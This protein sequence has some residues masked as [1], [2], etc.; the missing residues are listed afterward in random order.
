MS[1]S[2][3]IF[4]ELQ[5]M[6]AGEFAHLN[7]S[8]EEHLYGTEALLRSWAASEHVCRAGLF[9]AAYGTAGFANS[10]TPI[11]LR[12]EIRNLIGQQAEH[13][14][15][16]YCACDRKKFY[17]S[18]GSPEQNQLPDRFAGHM[19]QLDPMIL[20]CFCE[21]TAANELEIATKSQPFRDQH[22]AALAE[23]FNRMGSHLSTQAKQNAAQVLAEQA[24]NEVLFG[25]TAGKQ[26]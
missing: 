4:R 6:G 16:L 8:L 24:S 25:L 13:L 20:S 2:Q 10:L 5:R 18:F 15:Y 17:P 12:G 9:H 14:V 1:T 26:E 19:V 3:E 7:G 11:E 21:L 23:L 22:G